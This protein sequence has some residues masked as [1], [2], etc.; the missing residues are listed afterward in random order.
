M[1]PDE[2]TLPEAGAAP[3]R[4]EPAYPFWTYRDVG[5]LLGLII[6]VLVAA[7]VI[8]NLLRSAIPGF[9]QALAAGLL[10]TQFLGFGLWFLCLWALFRLRYRRPFWAS[11]GWR[12]PARGLGSYAVWGP[13]L[14]LGVALVGALLRTPDIQMPMK[15]LL[16]DRQSLVLVGVFAITL[17]P[18]C[19][20]LAF[21]GF[22]LPLPARTF[23]EAGGVLL[24]AGLFSLV[25]GPQYAWSWRHL[26]LITGAGAAFGFVRLRS[27]STLA[28][29]VMHATYNLTFFIAYLS[30]SGGLSRP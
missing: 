5:A 27:G 28:A 26:I 11:L 14:A 7:A 12:R 10:L 22:L 29:T 16:A 13:L 20:E 4:P 19:E 21:R 23:G 15:Q 2:F 3:P 24:I 30:Q 6:P 18:L 9:P 17:G 25:H 8:V 1:N